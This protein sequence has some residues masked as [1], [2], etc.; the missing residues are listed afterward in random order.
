MAQYA[1][2][3]FIHIHQ[4]ELLEAEFDKVVSALL[5]VSHTKGNTNFLKFSYCLVLLGDDDT[6]YTM[7]QCCWPQ[8]SDG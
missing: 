7:L 8:S 2:L 4:I 6:S 3:L 5:K 1:K